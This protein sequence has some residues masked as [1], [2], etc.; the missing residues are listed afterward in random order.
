M[1]KHQGLT[2]LELLFTI[3]IIVLLVS[4][5]S[6]AFT[7]I[8]KNIQ[9]KGVVENHY[10][11]FQ[12]ARYSAISNKTDVALSFQAG[13]KWCVGISDLGKC[14]CLIQNNCTLNG[15]EHL[16]A[17]DDYSLITLTDIKFGKDS[18][19]IFDGLRGLSIGN[20][21]SVVFSDGTRKLKLVLSNMGRVRICGVGS[22][23]SS[24]Q[25]C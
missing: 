22:T 12:Q 3:S 4:L 1:F 20:A 23:V 7:A 17:S 16:I 5:A 8:Q 11:A 2:L 13:T 15:I 14:N 10:F 9:L 21:G 25:K 24:Y 6:P 19:A 18:V